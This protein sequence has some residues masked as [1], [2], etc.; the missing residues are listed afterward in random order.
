MSH[1][2]LMEKVDAMILA[3]AEACHAYAREN[4]R[5]ACLEG[6][7]TE[8]QRAEIWQES[9]SLWRALNPIGF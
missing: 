7:L 6:E 3:R 1:S 2:E 5:Q 9:C 4:V 8:E